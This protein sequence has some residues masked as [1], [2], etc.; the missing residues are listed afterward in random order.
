MTATL[1]ATAAETVETEL[2]VEGMTCGACA[3]RI[4][5]KLRKLDGVQAN[6]NYATGRAAV[7]HGATVTVDDLVAAV[8]RAGYR[9]WQPDPATRDDEAEA[10]H[11]RDLAALGQ[12][13]IACGALAAPVIVLSMVPA[14][15]FPLWQWT[16]L[17]LTTPVV[18]WGALPIHRAALANLRHAAA[19]MD[20]LVSLGTLAAF[21]WSVYA[22]VFG[23][24]GLPGLTHSFELT[25]APADAAGQ[26]YLEVAAGVTTFVLAGRYLEARARR[27]SGSALRGLLALAAT[28]ARV[29]RDGREHLVPADR[30]AVG[31]TF[32]VRPGEKVATDEVVVDG[33]CALDTSAITGEPA[34]AD[35]APG[36]DVI[37]GCVALG[38]RLV[39]RATR[40][41]ADTQLAQTAALVER[42][43]NGKAAV[44]RLAD[45]VC[46][47]FVP[48]V[49]MLAAA[50][51]GFWTGAGAGA[52]T[53]LAAATAVLIVACPCA[54]GLATPTA[55][56]VGT[57]R[58]AQLGV[59]VTGPAVLESTRRIDT[60]VLD[61]TGTVTTGEMTVTDVVAADGTNVDEVLV[62]A[63]ALAGTSTH[64]VAQ[65]VAR[66][67]AGND[68]RTG[69]EVRDVVSLDG[70]G[71]QGV[72]D[73]EEVLLGR[74]SLLQQRGIP[75]PDTFAEP[76]AE[77]AAKG[78]T[79]VAVARAGRATAVLVL[80]DTIRPTSADAIAEL[81][82]L[83]LEPVLLTG[84]GVGAARAVADT[85]GITTVLADALPTD[86]VDHI[87][88]L[89]A[90]GRV[91]AMVGDGINDAAA[92]AQA[93]LGIAMGTGTDIAISAADITLVRADLTAAVDAVT[94]SRR[95]LTVIKANLT[96]A[97]GYNILALPV[98]AAGML[99][100]M[101]AGAAMAASSVL[102]V[103]NSLRLGGRVRTRG[104]GAAVRPAPLSHAAGESAPASSGGC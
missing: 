36:D 3:A 51:W 53:A 31:D 63:G 93:D 90:E 7:V 5:R 16:A 91:V 33:S 4:E 57:G 44:Q 60:I 47:E 62:V 101:L 92:L 58:A 41:G 69:P 39:V 64:P 19:T 73:G 24:A 76:L 56:L 50:T 34:P 1:P 30:L 23:T 8:E 81:R 46:G 88:R 96:W 87:A 42:A 98:A 9:A 38:G 74:L 26:I 43:Q 17:G 22:M 32:V 11:E 100:P 27:R 79:T 21:L 83:G 14:L 72:I 45:R 70:L 99:H 20:T 25:L 15:Q 54:L 89:Q 35:V 6:V 80:S 28:D 78:R 18:L 66:H 67:A 55:L 40:V 86:K 102:V 61:K 10:A 82:R 77:A 103:T 95:T 13:L 37:G 52:A 29:L 65:A 59:L 68:G 49:L 104:R 48:V 97:F 94:I 84:D 2:L 75:I 85:V 71:M 12:Q